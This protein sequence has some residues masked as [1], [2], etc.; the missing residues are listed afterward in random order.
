MNV[1][2]S[3]MKWK[4]FSGQSR[5]PCLNTEIQ[6]N[7]KL[8]I[9]NL[10]QFFIHKNMNLMKTKYEFKRLLRT[11]AMFAA[12][13][14]LLLTFSFMANAQT[15]LTVD[16]E[17]YGTVKVK[18]PGNLEAYA[19]IEGPIDDGPTVPSVSS[20]NQIVVFKEIAQPGFRF[21]EWAG[22]PYATPVPFEPGPIPPMYPPVGNPDPQGYEWALTVLGHQTVKAIFEL[23]WIGVY[24][25]TQTADFDVK[26]IPGI[27][28]NAKGTPVIVEI[29]A[30]YPV[31]TPGDF[32]GVLVDAL[33]QTDRAGGFTGLR[34]LGITPNP[35]GMTFPIELGLLGDGGNDIFV[36]DIFAAGIGAAWAAPTLESQSGATVNWVVTLDGFLDEDTFEVLVSTVAYKNKNDGDLC[37]N[38]LATTAI[39]VT[40]EGVVSQELNPLALAPV[41]IVHCGGPF[42]FE[43]LIEY[44]EIVNI[45]LPIVSNAQISSTCDLNGATINWSVTGGFGDPSGTY[46]VGAVLPTHLSTIVGGTVPME[47]LSLLS[48]DWHFEF[49]D[50]P[51]GTF[52]FTMQPVMQLG[53]VDYP[54]GEMLVMVVTNTD[55]DATANIIPSDVWSVTQTPII[56]PIQTQFTQAGS[57]DLEGI[58]VDARFFR[59]SPDVFPAGF[60]IL[61]ARLNGSPVAGNYPYALGGLT[62]VFFS[63]LFTA[64]W[65]GAFNGFPTTLENWEFDFVGPDAGAAFQMNFEIFSTYNGSEPCIVAEDDVDFSFEAAVLV[66][67]D[68][69]DGCLNDPI[70]FELDF[71]Y[72]SD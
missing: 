56:L 36:S 12:V 65:P 29:D 38:T 8:L 60:A 49:V 47:D 59:M 2:Q 66:A 18:A 67:D 55:V 3:I 16:I 50:V 51:P 41:Q 37:L 64:G 45:G 70:A 53:G 72:P 5:A 19:V 15:S 4:P 54:Y 43:H 42:E 21:K 9:Q 33:L 40:V 30:T 17:C 69:V 62:E 58:M 14:S 68:M 35:G 34:V 46:G 31:I 71:T 1:N 27:D 57:C 11:G 44:P 25:M 10:K 48:L 23:D 26:T 22:A 63:D 32:P 28:P 20:P 61:G 6:S 24:T 13:L 52:T 39:D 7:Y